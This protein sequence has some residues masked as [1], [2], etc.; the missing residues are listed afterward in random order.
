[1]TAIT[2]T[3]V[4]DHSEPPIIVVT[5]QITTNGKVIDYFDS[6]AEARAFVRGFQAGV[7]AGRS[8]AEV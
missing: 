1:M 6:P 4:E 7:E 8:R 3:R 5:Y 2:V